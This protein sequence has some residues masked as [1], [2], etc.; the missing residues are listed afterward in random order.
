VTEAQ[1]V[2][3]LRKKLQG[4]GY[5][6]K[7]FNDASTHG[8]P[9]SFIASAGKGMFVE[10]KYLERATF[11][12][13]LKSKTMWGKQIQLTTM[14]KLD[15]HFRA[16]YVVGINV[17]GELWIAMIRPAAVLKLMQENIPITV[18]PMVRV[19]SFVATLFH[20]MCD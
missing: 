5:Y 19:E 15:F 9:D 12:K 10:F 18:Q 4:S 14:L 17:D 11:P 7:K 3:G 20:R 16:R 6:V 13:V 2:D 8:L 1:F